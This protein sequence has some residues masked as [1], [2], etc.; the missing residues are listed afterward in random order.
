MGERYGDYAGFLLT[1]GIGVAHLKD[2]AIA[3]T[4]YVPIGPRLTAVAMT[5]R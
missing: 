2:M 4:D 1:R 5:G 3:G